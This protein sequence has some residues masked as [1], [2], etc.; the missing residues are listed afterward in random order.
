MEKANVD[1]AAITYHLQE[2]G[3][4]TITECME[5]NQEEYVPYFVHPLSKLQ[6]LGKN[7]SDVTVLDLVS[8]LTV[9]SK[10]EVLLIATITEGQRLNP[11]WLD[12]HQWRLTVSD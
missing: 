11:L 7:P 4:V 5:Q 8:A 3:R 12:A 10:Q 9:S 1:A 2:D 6:E